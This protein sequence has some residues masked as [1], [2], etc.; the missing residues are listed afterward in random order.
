[1]LNTLVLEML[2]AGRI[3]ELTKMLEDE[4]YEDSLKVKPGAKKR[5]AAMKKYF[6][7]HTSV[8]ECLQKPYPVVFED[9]DY[10]SFTNSWSLVLTTEDCGEIEMYDESNGKYP[11]V[12]R[13]IR[14]DG[15][16]KKLNFREVIAEAKSKGY[17]LNKKE[18]DSRFTYLLLFDGTYYK[19]GLLD[20]TYSI[21]DNGEIAMTYHPDGERMPLTIKNDI[22]MCM[23]MPVKYEDGVD[24]EADGKIVIKVEF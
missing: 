22:G 4:I 13:L 11:D 7:Y 12:T 18:V 21:I 20:A 16:K 5:Y 3:E 15:I 17:R 8:R 19:I 23:I 1:M 2:N 9:K 14:F 24:P 10:I 6:K